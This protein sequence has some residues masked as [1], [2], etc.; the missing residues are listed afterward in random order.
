MTERLELPVYLF[1]GFLEAG[2]TTFIQETLEDERFNHGERTLLLVCEEGMEEYEPERFTGGGVVIQTV[3]N[4]EDLTVSNFLMWAR[5][6]MADRV[7]VE[8]NGMWMLDSLYKAL[9]PRW[10][11]VQ[12]FMFADSN[13]FL[14]YN[15]NLRQHTYDKLKSAEMVIFN[16]WDPDRD[17]MPFHKA[18]R[19]AAR[20]SD[21]GY[22]TEDG[23]LEYDDIYDPLPYD[24]NAPVIEVHND[25]YAV[26]YREMAEETRKY[27]GRKVSFVALSVSREGMPPDCFVVGRKVMTCCELDIEFH[28]FACVWNRASQVA[29]GRWLRITAET[30]CR[31]HELYGHEGPVLNILRVEDA[32]EPDEPVATFR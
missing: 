20:C 17:K 32:E 5:A 27:A 7:I 13:T 16:R 26:F 25:D 15:L 8:Y 28:E 3:E 2:K 11:L 9:P 29:D 23:Y 19:G 6:C 22:Q 24:I 4:E 31:Y 18:V 1:T 30:E 12:E 21:I 10:I 14:S